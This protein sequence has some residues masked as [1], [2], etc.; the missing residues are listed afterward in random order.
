MIEVNRYGSR[1]VTD[2]VTPHS[3]ICDKVI[4]IRRLLSSYTLY[5]WTL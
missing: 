3:G 5:S 2:R 1:T 4:A